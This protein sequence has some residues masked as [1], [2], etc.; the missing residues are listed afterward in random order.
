MNE[1]SKDHPVILLCR[2]PRRP[3]S[4]MWVNLRSFG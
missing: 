2:G 1:E 4:D 3:W